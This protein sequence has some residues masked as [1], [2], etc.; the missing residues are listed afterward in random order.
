MFL[1]GTSNYAPF[2]ASPSRDNG[3]IITT[4]NTERVRGGLLSELARA[5]AD[6]GISCAT[7]SCRAFFHWLLLNVGKRHAERRNAPERGIVE[8]QSNESH[9]RRSGITTLLLTFTALQGPV[10]QDISRISSIPCEP[11]RDRRSPGSSR[12]IGP[13]MPP[14][15]FGLG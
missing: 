7:P 14:P 3:L 10:T 15:D 6:C 11:D 8:L 4:C 1:S 9:K 5:Y 2:A 13:L 12:G